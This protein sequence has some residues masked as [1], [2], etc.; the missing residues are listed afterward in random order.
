MAAALVSVEERGSRRDFQLH[1][2]AKANVFVRD[3]K[4]VED[5]NH[6]VSGEGCYRVCF[7]F[8]DVFFF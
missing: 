8:L 2:S 6:V 4:A 5:R 7:V 1:Y 3:C